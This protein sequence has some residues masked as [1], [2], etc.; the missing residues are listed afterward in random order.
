MKYHEIPF[1]I[2]MRHQHHQHQHYQQ[3]Q[4]LSIK[5]Q[6]SLPWIASGTPSYSQPARAC[7]AHFCACQPS[8][9][10]LIHAWLS[11]FMR[12]SEQFVIAFLTLMM[13]YQKYQFMLH[14][15]NRTGDG[16]KKQKH[17][18]WLNT[19]ESIRKKYQW[20]A[21][22]MS[23]SITLTLENQN[24]QYAN[25]ETSC[26]IL[27][28]RLPYRRVHWI[29][30]SRLKKKTKN[31]LPPTS[32]LFMAQS[33]NAGTIHP[34]GVWVVNCSYKAMVWTKQIIT[35]TAL[36]AATAGYTTHQFFI[37]AGN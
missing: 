2:Q 17:Q 20:K 37:P 33:I 35:P 9:V 14:D 32:N 28:H 6:R 5:L 36:F 23:L 18:S 12:A 21:L 27:G 7:T 16:C 30:E 10:G 3:R 4:L 15:P 1:S 24:D 29:E 22:I 31:I 26:A 11:C 8:M 34:K 25:H 13:D 19:T